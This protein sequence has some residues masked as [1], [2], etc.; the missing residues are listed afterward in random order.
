MDKVFE[1]A[2]LFGNNHSKN[3]TPAMKDIDVI[4][5]GDDIIIVYDVGQREYYNRKTDIFLT[6]DD[7]AY[8]KLR[9]YSL[10]TTPLP[11]PLPFDYFTRWKYESLDSDPIFCDWFDEVLHENPQTRKILEGIR[12]EQ[13]KTGGSTR[14]AIL[15]VLLDRLGNI[16]K[17]TGKTI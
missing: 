1:F 7:I 15:E 11:D 6:D 9:P 8:Y 5:N 10:I 13:N 17:S 2:R 14:T 4:Y 12:Y 16:L 3:R